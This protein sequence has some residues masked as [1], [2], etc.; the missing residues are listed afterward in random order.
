VHAARAAMHVAGVAFDLLFPVC[1]VH[2]LCLG[3][4]Q[5]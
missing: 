4:A 1:H 5:L 3:L 2:E